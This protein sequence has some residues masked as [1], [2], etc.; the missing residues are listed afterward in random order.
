MRKTPII[1]TPDVEPCDLQEIVDSID[2]ASTIF[3]TG[4]VAF[5]DL[6]SV[7]EAIAVTSQGG[8]LASRLASLGKT[9]CESHEIEF[10]HYQ[11][12]YDLDAE[13]FAASLGIAPDARHE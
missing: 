10:D 6:R 7:F 3:G 13:R 11:A 4:C 5:C 2:K 1:H 8:T 12:T 9:L